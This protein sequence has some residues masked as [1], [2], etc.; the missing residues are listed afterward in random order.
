MSCDLSIVI[1]AFDEEACIDRTLSELIEVLEKRDLHY[2]LVVVDN[3]SSDGTFAVLE[4]VRKR[5]PQMVVIRFPENLGFGGAIAR[6]LSLCSGD[7]VGFTCADGEVPA[8][9]VVQMYDLLQSGHVDL[10]KGKRIGRTNL[11]RQVWSV[12]YHLVVGLLFEIHITD[13]NGY[14]VLARRRV[15]EDMRFSR[16]NWMINIEI[17]LY[18]RQRG[19]STAELDVR[20]RE[21]L[22][23]RSHVRWYFPLVFL[24]Q[25]V[26]FRWW[27]WRRG[28]AT[29]GMAVASRSTGGAIGSERASP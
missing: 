26:Q 16:T 22:G 19:L 11:R 2:E 5:H 9:S 13:I 6:G 14:P 12:G 17:L 8:E 20:Y 7:V 18:A 1:P 24:A 3:G 4:E 21:R 10:C 29:R 23:G 28:V 15:V 25:L 27:L